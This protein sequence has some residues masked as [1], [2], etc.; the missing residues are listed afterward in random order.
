MHDKEKWISA[1]EAANYLG[2]TPE[3]LYSGNTGVPLFR[4]G[5]RL[6]TRYSILDEWILQNK[7]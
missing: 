6:V 4:I 7:K 3:N 2:T 1:K 5:K